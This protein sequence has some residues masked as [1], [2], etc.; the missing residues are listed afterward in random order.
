MNAPQEQ[1]LYELRRRNNQLAEALEAAEADLADAKLALADAPTEHEALANLAETEPWR[2]LRSAAAIH[3]P[4]GR[5]GI[6]RILR[7]KAAELD[8]EHQ[9]AVERDRLAVLAEIAYNRAVH[10]T[11]EVGE[12]VMGADPVG[13]AAAV[14]AVLAEAVEQQ[15][16]SGE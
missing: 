7:S 13:M 2:V 15:P 6:G 12:V 4:E 3:D 1:E 10:D 11:A 16:E 9:A 14:A 5:L 8:R